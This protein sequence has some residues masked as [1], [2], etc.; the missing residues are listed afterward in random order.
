MA[1][2]EF[3]EETLTKF[4]KVALERIDAAGEEAVWNGGCAQCGWMG[5]DRP[6]H[7]E[8]QADAANHKQQTGHTDV[9]VLGPF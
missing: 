9:G 7:E 1:K 8:A 2:F 3:T 6:S 5:P 4:L